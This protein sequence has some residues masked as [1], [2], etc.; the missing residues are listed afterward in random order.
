VAPALKILKWVG[1]GAVAHPIEIGVEF[2]VDAPFEAVL[3]SGW[4]LLRGL[5]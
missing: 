4:P 2:W 1:A 3:I 5:R